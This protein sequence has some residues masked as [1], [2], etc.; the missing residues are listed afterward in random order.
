[1]IKALKAIYLKYKKM[2]TVNRGGK[3]YHANTN[4]KKAGICMLTSDILDFKARC[5]TNMK[6]KHFIVIKMSTYQ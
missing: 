1:M 5:I 4:Q 3:L 2:C 6:D